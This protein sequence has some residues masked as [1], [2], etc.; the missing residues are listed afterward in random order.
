MPLIARFRKLPKPVFAALLIVVG[1]AGR[2][3]LL[4]AANVEPVLVIS[5]FAGA[6]LGGVYAVVVPVAI[7][8]ASDAIVYAF[9]YGGSYGLGSVLGLAA[10]V[11]SGYAFVGLCGGWALRRRLL[12]RTK[13]VAL[14]TAISIPLTVAYDAWTAFGDWMFIAG[15]S[16]RRATATVLSISA[17]DGSGWWRIGIAGFALKFWTI[18]S[19][20]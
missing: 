18:T 10:F 14:F 15:P 13:T 2:V 7:M 11:Y 19:W 20:M 4:P 5:M 3:A 12:W 6:A 17:S 8:A 1:I 16:K 9:V